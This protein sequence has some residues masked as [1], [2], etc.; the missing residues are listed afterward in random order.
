LA[1]HPTFDPDSLTPG[2]PLALFLSFFNCAENHLRVQ[3]KS[4]LRIAGMSEEISLTLTN[5]NH[6]IGIANNRAITAS[7]GFISTK[8]PKPWA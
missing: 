6:P 4:F 3:L 8:R 2:I 5:C 7:V 1:P